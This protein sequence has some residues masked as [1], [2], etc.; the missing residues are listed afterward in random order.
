M[1][2]I[3]SA[4]YNIGYIERLS[5]LDTPVHRLDP[6]A[7]LITALVF[8]ATVVS[9]DKYTIS[10]LLIFFLYPV[11]TAGLG[12]ISYGYLAKN[13]LYVSPFAVLVGIFNPLFDRQVLV[14]IGNT[15]ISGGWISFLSIVM[16]FF[17]TVSAGFILIGTSG[18]FSICVALERLKVPRLFVV[19]LM[20]LYRYIFVLIEETIGL[21]RARHLRSFDGRG[22]GMAVAGSM[23]GNLLLRT[24]NRARR[25]HVSMLSRG[26]DG[27]IRL[28][29]D[30]R[31]D[32]ASLLYMLGWCLLFIVMRSFNIP[33]IIGNFAGRLIL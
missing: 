20:F 5:A 31:M 30:L 13:I 8:I 25:I 29:K 15:G 12:N 21:V 3:E 9:F 18:F 10:N 28:M 23:M 24:I 11:I 26:F 7:K 33:V 2:K 6:R 27:E 22:M 4:Y 14:T 1:P 32:P 16:K 17:L 19:Q